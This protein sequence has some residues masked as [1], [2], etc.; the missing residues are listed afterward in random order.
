MAKA[1]SNLSAL[2]VA[3][4]AE[5]LLS[6]FPPLS[7]T[8]TL[9]SAEASS[10][11][12]AS[13]AAIPASSLTVA[14]DYSTDESSYSDEEMEKEPKNRKRINWGKFPHRLRLKSAIDDWDKKTGDALDI[15]GDVI[16]SKRLFSAIVGIPFKTFAPYVHPNKKRR[17][18]LGNGL[19]G[20][21]KV[22]SSGDV[23]FIAE[24]CARADR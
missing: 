8:A 5:D 7:S 11:L 1:S 9:G 17:R 13:T 2:T 18:S 19:R 12:S 24:V 14:L 16:S 4:R 10:N 23:E 22:L 15:N 21:E 6:A 3:M 20:K